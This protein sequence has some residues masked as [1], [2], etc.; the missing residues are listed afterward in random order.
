M[1]NELSEEQIS[2][3]KEKVK[4]ICEEC[5]YKCQGKGCFS[6]QMETKNEPKN[7]DINRPNEID[8]AI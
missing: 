7:R 5:G 1:E 8:P 2:L 3:V 6:L 4:K